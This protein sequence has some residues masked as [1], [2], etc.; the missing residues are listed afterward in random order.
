[1]NRL[2]NII[3]LAPSE[4]PFTDLIT[5]LQHERDRVRAALE[6]FKLR[7]IRTTKKARSATS[8]DEM[9]IKRM[10]KDGEI[11]KAEILDIIRK[12]KGND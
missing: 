11:T 12:A 6:W 10:M 2:V 9:D 1:M 7:P 5:K 4:L 8:S 3:G